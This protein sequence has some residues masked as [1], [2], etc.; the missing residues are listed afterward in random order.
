VLAGSS[1][2]RQLRVPAAVS[3]KLKLRLVCRR[4]IFVMFRSAWLSMTLRLPLASIAPETP[5]GFHQ[6]RVFREKI[7]EPRAKFAFCHRRSALGLTAPRWKRSMLVGGREKTRNSRARRWSCRAL[8]YSPRAAMC[9]SGSAVR[10]NLWSSARPR[11]SYA[12]EEVSSAT[13][14]RKLSL[15]QRRAA[16]IA[17]IPMLPPALRLPRLVIGALDRWLRVAR[18]RLSWPELSSSA[19]RSTRRAEPRFS[20]N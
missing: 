12:R 17:W 7:P 4:Q 11:A 18:I 16:R 10:G 3:S 1:N 6:P 8:V 2:P 15:R 14:E 19:A 20:S 9:E 13:A 5:L